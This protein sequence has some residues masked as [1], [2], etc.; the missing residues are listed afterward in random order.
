[1]GVLSPLRRFFSGKSDRKKRQHRT[2]K[3][4]FR[5]FAEQNPG[6]VFS[7]RHFKIADSSDSSGSSSGKTRSLSRLEELFTRNDRL[8]M[9]ALSSNNTNEMQDLLSKNQTLL[10]EIQAI[11]HKRGKDPNKLHELLGA[12]PNTGFHLMYGYS[13]PGAQGAAPGVPWATGV[14]G[15]PWATGVPGVPGSTGCNTPIHIEDRMKELVRNENLP[16][17]LRSFVATWLEEEEGRRRTEAHDREA[18]RRAALGVEQIKT[19]AKAFGNGAVAG[20]TLGKAVMSRAGNLFT[21]A[22]R[23]IFNPTL[24]TM[25]PPLPPGYVAPVAP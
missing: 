8:Y 4:A 6:L 21:R 23:A 17:R 12:A 18:A 14:P 20:T 22:K 9:M 25:G 16:A 19:G 5:T 13:L 15:V 7:K 11:L 3:R 24:P 1:M 10:H 2:L